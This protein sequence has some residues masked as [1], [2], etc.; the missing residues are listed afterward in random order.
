MSLDSNSVVGTALIGVD[1]DN[2]V[3]LSNGNGVF[4]QGLW[5]KLVLV[6]LKPI[7]HTF[8]IATFLIGNARL[9]RL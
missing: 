4:R 9:A 6:D 8:R 2:C 3:T 7:L 5:S 1:N